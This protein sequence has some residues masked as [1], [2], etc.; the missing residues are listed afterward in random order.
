ML[1]NRKNNILVDSNLTIIAAPVYGERIPQFLYDF[2]KQI[3]GNGNLLV[4]IS[5]YGNIGFGISLEQFEIFAKSNNF[6]LIAAGALIGQ[7]TYAT[8]MVPVAYGR[9]DVYDLQQTRNFGESIQ[10]KIDMKN[11]TSIL[12][13]K[14][15]L[16]KFITKFPDSGTRFLIRQPRVKKSVCNS[17]GACARKCLVGAIDINTLEINEQ[18]CLRCYACVKVCPKAARIAEFRLP[19]FRHMGLRK[20]KIRLFYKYVGCRLVP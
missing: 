19:V 2:F 15:V 4:A 11:F 8:E 17:C 18:K 16:P 10:K 3:R 1:E 12:L 20:K 14:V 5:V 9:P 6:R 7:H 13:P